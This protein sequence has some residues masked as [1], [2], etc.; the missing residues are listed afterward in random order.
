MKKFVKK[1]IED[2][3][4]LT[5]M[6]EGM[7]FHYLKAPGSGTY[8]EQLSLRISGKIDTCLFEKAW[9]V[10]IQ[11]NEMLRAV[12]RWEKLEKPSQIILKKRPCELRFHDLSGLDNYWKRPALEEIKTK[13]RDEGFDLTRVPFRVILCKLDETVFEMV[14]SNHHILYDGWSNGII[15]K[16]FFNAYHSLSKGEQPLTLPAKPSF[17]EFIKWIQNQDSNKHKQFWS[18]YLAGFETTTELPIKRR[19]EETT[20]PR[21]YSIILE[22]DIKSK[23]DVFVKNNRITLA[24]VFYSAWGILLQK[25]CGSEDVIFGTTVSGR[26]V[27]IKGIE[28]MV[29]LFIN[30]IPLRTQTFPNEKIIGVVFQTNQVLRQ[31]E[32]FENTPLVDIR[33]YSSV[34]GG[35]SLFD[36]IVAIENYPLDS[37]L[38]PQE[39]SLSINSF[40]MVEMPHYDLSAAIL[41][42]N[43]IEVKLS[44]NPGFFD[45]ET[46]KN[47]TGHFK[48]IIQNIIENPEAKLSQLE[49][50]SIEEKSRILYEFNNTEAEYPEDKTIY[51]LFAEQVE[52]TPDHI[53]VIGSTVESL[54]AASLQIT[55]R[56]LNEQANRLAYLLIE[57]GVLADNIVEIMV[58]RSVEMIIG[59]FGILKANGAYLPIDPD[60]PKDR[61]DYILKDSSAKLLI[62][63]RNKDGEKVRNWGGEKV[64][65]EEIF[66]SPGIPTS[67]LTF[68]PPYPQNSSNLAYIIYTSGSTGKPKGVMIENRSLIN[69]IKGITD[70]IPFQENDRILSLTTISF[71]IFGLETILPLTKG[72]TI[73]IG[74]AEEQQDAVLAARIMEREA[75]TIFQATPSRLQ[76]FIQGP[77][78]GKILKRLKYLLVGGEVL[79]EALLVKLKQL[80]DGSIYNVYG[81][82]ETTIWSTIKEVSG[83]NKLNIGKPLVN[84]FIY[85]L[86][87]DGFLQPVDAA[88][89]IC[90][91]GEGVARGYINRPELMKEKF[92]PNPF[93]KGARLYYTGD[94]GR[95]LPDGNIECLGR[96]DQ[97]VK[98]RGFRIEPGEIETLLLKHHRI[99]DAVVVLKGDGTNDKNLAAYFISDIELSDIE[100]REYLLKDLPEYMIP[101]YF[102]GI[103]KLPLTPS[104][105]IDRRSLPEPIVC[106]VKEYEAPR[107]DIEKKLVEI[108]STVLGIE[109]EK[110]G[111]NTNFFRLGGHSLKATSLASGIYKKFNVKIP[112]GEIFKRPTVRGLF[113]YINGA[114]GEPYILIEPVEKK[115][116]YV[117][118]SAQ[119]RLYFLQQMHKTTA[120]YNMPSAWIL[121]GIIDKPLLEKSIR[122]LIRR[123]ESLRTSFE[124]INEEPV[125]KIHEQ[126]EFHIEISGVSS[127]EPLWRADETNVSRSPGTL[128]PKSSRP[129]EAIIKSFIRPFDLSK[130][131]LLRVGLVKLAEERHLFLVDMHHIISDEISTGILIHEF[132]AFYSKEKLPEIGLRYKDYAGWQSR[133]KRNK[134]L[135][136]QEEYWKKE[137]EGEIP[138]LELPTDYERPIVRDFEGDSINSEINREVSRA[139][140]TLAL[141]TGTTLYM[142]L[143]PI[144]GILLEKLSCQVDIV[145]GTPAAGRKYAELGNIIGMFVN[146]LALRI[147]PSG[148]KTFYNF[149][150]ELKRTTIQT[151]EN[152]DY[153]YENLIK[154]V[155]ADRNTSRNPLFDTMF[156]FQNVNL[157][158]MEIPGLKLIPYAYENKISKFDLTLFVGEIE[159]KISLRLEY[160]TKLFK[161]ETAERFIRYFKNIIHCV[162]KNKTQRISEIEILTGE[163]KN[164]LLVEFNDTGCDYPKDKTLHQL[165]E[166]QVERTPDHT[167]IVAP[168]GDTNHLS[169][170]SKEAAQASP[171]HDVKISYRHLNEKSN[172]LA[173]RLRTRGVTVDNIVGLLD[174]GSFEMIAGLL[175][176][177][178]AGGAYLPMDPGTPA[179]RIALILKNSHSDL[180]LTRRG[181]LEMGDI[182]FAGEILYL[183]DEDL[184]PCS[185]ANMEN[186]NQPCDLAYLIYTSGSTGKPKGIA[187][188]HRGVVNY[189]K[190]AEAFYLKNEKFQFPLCSSLAFDLTVTSIYVPLVSG[191]TIVL[192]NIEDSEFVIS[193]IIRDGL[194][195]ILK[196]T[197]SHLGMLKYGDTEC[198]GIRRLIV[199]G[200][201]LT[202]KL[203]AETVR[204]FD[205]D[206]EIYN[207]YGPTE[208]IVGCMIHKY[209]PAADCRKSVPIGIP[210]A[211]AQIYIL[212][213]N[214]STVP[215][216]VAGELCISGDGLAR[217]YLNRPELTAEK[218]ITHPWIPGKLMYRTGDRAR[219]LPDEKIEFLGRLDDQVKIRG[220]RV[221][222]NEIEFLLLKHEAIKEVV[223]EIVKSPGEI[224]T[225]A[226][227]AYIVSDR[228]LTVKEMREHL[229]RNVPDYMI[230]SY[231]VSLE[232]IPLTPSGKVNRK[233][234]PEPEVK[235][236]G[237]DEAPA[238]EIEEMLIEIWKD[239]LKIEKINVNDNFFE[240]SGDSI[241]AIQLIYR[242]SKHKMKFELNDLFL[243]PT[244]RQLATCIKKTEFE[245][246]QR[247]VAGDVPLTSVQRWFFSS[248][249]TDRHHYNQSLVLH[250][251]AGFCEETVR[252]VFTKI[253]EHHDALRMVYD[254]DGNRVIQENRGVDGQFSQLFYLETFYLE[255]SE[256]ITEKIERETGRMQTSIDLSHGPM[257]KLGLFQT[258]EGDYLS[259]IIHHLVIDGVSWRILL[260][261]F[262]S[263]YRQALEGEKMSLPLKTTSFKEWGEKL[264]DHA[265]GKQPAMEIPFWR[266]MEQ[267]RV[268]PLLKDRITT[269]PARR[270]DMKQL[271]LR[272]SPDYTGKLLKEVNK[273]YNTRITDILLA[274]LGLALNDWSAR[275]RIG[276]ALEG[277]GRDYPVKNINLS[278]TVGWFTAIFPVIIDIPKIG[279]IPAVI[280]K[281]KE[282]LRRIPNNGTGYG[283]LRYMTL[284]EKKENILFQLK[285]EICF[286]YLG[287]FDEMADRTD[288]L[289]Q[290]V[291]IPVGTPIGPDSEGLYAL[292]ISGFVSRGE[293]T[294]SVDYDSREY[295]EKNISKFV[296]LYEKHLKK[297]ILHC[298]GKENTEWS[299]CD[300]TSEDISENEVDGI[301]D[302]LGDIFPN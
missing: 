259:I 56:Q 112:L 251:P 41:L 7:L 181:I 44:Y 22:E 170:H 265:T 277:H 70:I 97:Q 116:Y 255:N 163:E 249:K 223:I 154:N 42:F 168:C 68:L 77:E 28:D 4:A 107:N 234:L 94:I 292:D 268:L 248:I 200:E 14:I 260:E 301:F 161:K 220:N 217:G 184:Y 191:N 160:C 3:L 178:K 266:K 199:G 211:N 156:V 96:I 39:H 110:I 40:S 10:V 80:T 232:K 280:K 287:Q 55:Y 19:V 228:E 136:K 51:E 208:A 59:I 47:L 275:D 227:C 49:I 151:L 82:T 204:F 218:F 71:D 133:E 298:T 91:S 243:N 37:R 242:L 179:E 263:L 285:P 122:A 65:L 271:T 115:E 256:T 63:T 172:R 45:K 238:G 67:P 278:R 29:G 214:L 8:F 239:V 261:D 153:Q 108:W 79:P 258:A 254:F 302:E 98:L 120:A 262:S 290:V 216:G 125:Q 197:P 299:A 257:V 167:A 224:E 102:V 203:A 9:D 247:P 235:S 101:A 241:K 127:G 175:G 123:H 27:G 237:D 118:S 253:V 23:L 207:E 176:V 177:L 121:E 141:E 281:T 81:P 289:F 273:A 142:I 69:F 283:I 18:D 212:D 86:S 171:G 130:A 50:I 132:T 159:E 222:T 114:V 293:L 66:K 83:R 300:L 90:I 119:S 213:D 24:S 180:L 244:I 245:V 31:R 6:Q 264:M 226:L 5:P 150:E 284:P 202:S 158:T 192:Y 92:P 194:V 206:I 109:K 174:T 93:V 78:Q 60:Y 231:W 149:S 274:G 73:I 166:E 46:I 185:T 147:Y 36:T 295:H 103:E 21:D 20:S 1:S 198:R 48:G 146:T 297:I 230:P 134:D 219:W 58:E 129:P 252:V 240:M 126:V 76:L 87:R 279:G 104:G 33:S 13:D 143:L 64:L 201:N 2:I 233:A 135:L 182:E 106:N 296:N 288:P 61:I 12:F 155:S 276:V 162:L 75:V 25:Y 205:K 169:L 193:K 173:H 105:K 57:K 189:I 95:W 72:S 32:A 236:R 138:V 43:K 139:I 187:V 113:D 17:K 35:G 11:T 34:D 196:L 195:Q 15:L 267:T 62:T 286:N 215:V 16:E 111:I 294:I 89:E 250:R 164:R 117:S 137:F 124:L 270:K 272:L 140:K 269:T 131:P 85:I 210:I 229:S 157:K 54:H 152:Q 209:D 100:L 30:T 246:D 186:I 26:S 88:G 74:S 144:Y 188:E 148:E 128:S 165:F 221:E 145:I 291:N 38:L 183:D 225:C 99:K 84:T 53:A 282:I 52:R 190:W